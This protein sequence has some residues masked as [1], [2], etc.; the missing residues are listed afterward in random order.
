[1]FFI[2]YYYFSNFMNHF[3]ALS[4]RF[5]HLPPAPQN[6]CGRACS[7]VQVHKYSQE[8]SCLHRLGPLLSAGGCGGRSPYPPVPGGPRPRALRRRGGGRSGGGARQVRQHLVKN[9]Q[10]T[11][12]VPS[13]HLQTLTTYACLP[14]AVL[15]YGCRHA[16]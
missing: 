4:F 11:R 10:C 1:M 15:E 12:N 16:I 3:G 8:Y 7:A 9:T 2:N 14:V 5:E 6:V 13:P